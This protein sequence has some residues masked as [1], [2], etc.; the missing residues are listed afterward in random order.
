MDTVKATTCF[1]MSNNR[2][3]E[4]PRSRSSNQSRDDKENYPSS[5]HR[6]KT[7]YGHTSADVE[8]QI[9]DWLEDMKGDGENKPV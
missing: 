8:N 9:L 6:V 5:E 2:P 1:L 3:W 4:K 7:S